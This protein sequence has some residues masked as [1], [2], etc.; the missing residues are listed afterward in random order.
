MPDDNDI[1]QDPGEFRQHAEQDASTRPILYEDFYYLLG[2]YPYLEFSHIEATHYPTTPPNIVTASTGWKIHQYDELMI[3]SQSAL[4]SLLLTGIDLSHAGVETLIKEEQREMRKRMRAKAKG[5]P[6]AEDESD[7]GGSEGRIPPVGTIVNQFFTTALE[8]VGLVRGAN[9]PGIRL[10]RGYYPMQRAAWIACE[11][12]N[13]T[14]EG[15]EPTPEDHVVYSW[16]KTKAPSVFKR[17]SARPGR[18]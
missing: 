12:Q 14:C 10:I 11:N 15:F 2:R 3:S 1:N 8:M 17:I 4:L 5:E 9:W 7:K 18:R 16:V 13:L 6:L